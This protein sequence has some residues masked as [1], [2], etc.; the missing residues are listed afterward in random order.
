MK[1][2]DIVQDFQK[3]LREISNSLYLVMD[4][5]CF[6]DL[7]D[8]LRR[9]RLKHISLYLENVDPDRSRSGPF[10]VEIG[11]RLEDI[12]YIFRNHDVGVFWIWSLSFDELCKHL[13]SINLIY[14]E[15][16]GVSLFRHYDPV[17]LENIHGVLLPG[18]KKRLIGRADGIL[19]P[20]DEGDIR[21][22][23]I[24]DDVPSSSGSLRLT[25]KQVEEVELRHITVR[26]RSD[27]LKFNDIANIHYSHESVFKAIR[28]SHEILKKRSKPTMLDYYDL[29]TIYCL[30]GEDALLRSGMLEFLETAQ[31]PISDARALLN[32]LCQNALEK[33]SIGV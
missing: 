31:F 13:R 9:E 1:Y 10:L 3:Y 33:E 18:Q 23:V 21:K 5:A 6:E 25:S 11:D 8:N 14:L 27:I 28:W 22:I 17:V 12:F 16:S 20:C 15:G 30:Y 2:I 26:L 4:G 24:R 7:P 19:I 32:F 29:A